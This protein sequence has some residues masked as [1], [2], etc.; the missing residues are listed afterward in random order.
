[1]ETLVLPE[2]LFAS[3]LNSTLGLSPIPASFEDLNSL[4]ES[5]N[6]STSGSA[7]IT[8]IMPG[9]DATAISTNLDFSE[10]PLFPA[11]GSNPFSSSEDS[12][13]DI[14]GE[15]SELVSPGASQWESIETIDELLDEAEAIAVENLISFQE[16]DDY[17]EDLKI[18]F[19]EEVDLDSAN[20]LISSLISGEVDIEIETI[21]DNP[22]LTT[23]AFSF[24]ANSIYFS[25][26][27]LYQHLSNPETVSK[28]LLEEWGHYLDSAINSEDS[29]GDEGEIFANL[30]KGFSFDITDLKSDDDTAFLTIDDN[31]LAV[32]LAFETINLTPSWIA[33]QHVSGAVIGFRR[34]A[35]VSALTDVWF[36]GALYENN[37]V[38]S[39]YWEDC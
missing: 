2:E 36:N 17:F 13:A 9:D 20:S 7:E 39:K 5:L 28:I 14:L 26:D 35:T 21:I 25:E 37:Q 19:G 12:L 30:V 16:S 4:R 11:L 34:D 27:F 6:S 3:A 29:I 22:V 1:M 33:Y 8:P 38:L 32:E 18:A 24:E 31:S 23:G 15:A 10:F